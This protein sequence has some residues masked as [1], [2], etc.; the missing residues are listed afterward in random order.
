MKLDDQFEWDVNDQTNS[1]ELFA[2]VYANELGLSGE[3]KTAIV[4]SI[5]EQLYTFQK[6]LFLVGYPPD[7]S[8]IPDQD[9]K[10]FFLP[11]VTPSSI[12]RSA[13]MAQ[14][15]TPF[16]NSVDEI[17]LSISAEK[18][19]NRKRKARQTTR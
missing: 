16:L 10:E 14:G 8:S 15:Y 12:A 1:P 13:E 4:H 7:V 3:W 6:S 2:E 9:L 18:E 11:H 19:K 5:R 17:E